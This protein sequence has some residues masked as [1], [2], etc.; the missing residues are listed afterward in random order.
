MLSILYEGSCNSQLKGSMSLS[1]IYPVR[2]S[3]C[4]DVEYAQPVCILELGHDLALL[5]ALPLSHLCQEI[6]STVKLDPLAF[7]IE[8]VSHMT[9]RRL[10]PFSWRVTPLAVPCVHLLPR[11]LSLMAYDSLRVLR[12][13]ARRLTSRVSGQISFGL[14]HTPSF[15]E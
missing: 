3:G 5:S 2:M 12:Q 6:Q 14:K 10:M 4:P 1:T 7:C 8:Q 13:L 11:V 15:P 9:L